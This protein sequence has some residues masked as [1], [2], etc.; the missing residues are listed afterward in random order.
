MRWLRQNPNMF[1]SPP[2]LLH[3]ICH[4]LSS[5]I[6]TSQPR[7]FMISSILIHWRTWVLLKNVMLHPQPCRKRERSNL[8]ELSGMWINED[9][10]LLAASDYNNIIGLIAPLTIWWRAVFSGC[11]AAVCCILHQLRCT[12]SNWMIVELF[13][14]C[15]KP[16]LFRAEACYLFK[17]S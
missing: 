15:K 17:L 12:N 10:L 4:S 5:Y 6:S 3:F 16:K 14:H 11:C 13:N 7:H 2:P 8:M 1:S 9:K